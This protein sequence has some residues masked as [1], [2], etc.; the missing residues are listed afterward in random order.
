MAYDG[1]RGPRSTPAAA[2]GKSVTFQLDPE[3]IRVFAGGGA[4]PLGV[5]PTRILRLTALDTLRCPLTHNR[6][7]RSTFLHKK[8]VPTHSFLL[9]YRRPFAP[10]AGSR[11]APYYIRPVFG[12]DITLGATFHNHVRKR[13]ASMAR[14]HQRTV[15]RLEPVNNYSKKVLDDFKHPDAGGHKHDA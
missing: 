5:E 9:S 12:R 2:L 11:N 1:G 8:R 6:R 15:R 3:D 10:Q 4:G 14:S 13:L 7:A